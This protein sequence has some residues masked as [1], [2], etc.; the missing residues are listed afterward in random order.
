[1]P[2]EE[3]RARAL[4]NDVALAESDVVVVLPR[5]GKGREMYGEARLAVAFGIPVIWVGPTR[6]LTSYRAGVLCVDDVEAALREVVARSA[7]WERRLRAV[8]AA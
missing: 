4:A 6:C 2:I 8:D 7:A 5:E 1:M 3:L